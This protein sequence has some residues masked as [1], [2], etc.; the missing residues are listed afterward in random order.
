MSLCKSITL[1]EDCKNKLTISAI[2]QQQ[3]YFLLKEI[4]L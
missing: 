2:K 3:G 4:E 1:I